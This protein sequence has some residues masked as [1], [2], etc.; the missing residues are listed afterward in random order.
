MLLQEAWV[1]H[2]LQT[3]AQTRGRGSEPCW[4]LQSGNLF[5][6]FLMGSH[7]TQAGLELVI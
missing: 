6:F 4:E 2:S 7:V 5:F 3:K 1:S